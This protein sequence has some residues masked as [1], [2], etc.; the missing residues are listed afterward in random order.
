[1]SQVE[2]LHQKHVAVAKDLL[3][4][5]AV[6][7]EFLSTLQEDINNLKALLNAIAIGAF[8]P[9]RLRY[10]SARAPSLPPCGA[11]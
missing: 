8:S 6:L 3:P 10:F 9:H 1:M 4:A 11:D 7:D 2:A 5:G